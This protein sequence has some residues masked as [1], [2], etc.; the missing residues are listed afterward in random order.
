MFNDI[1]VS[2][3][4]IQVNSIYNK[5]LNWLYE[6]KDIAQWASIAP[7]LICTF[8]SLHEQPMS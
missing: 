6:A 8:F 2:T 1:L 7:I 3:Y 4:M 5:V